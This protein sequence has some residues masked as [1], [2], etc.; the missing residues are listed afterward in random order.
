MAVE[1]AMLFS[2]PGIRGV[3]EL[4][5]TSDQLAL[6]VPPRES[7]PL[8]LNLP[9]FLTSPTVSPVHHLTDDACASGAESPSPLQEFWPTIVHFVQVSPAL[10]QQWPMAYC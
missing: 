2:V 6:V 4:L 3:D 1:S 9:H 8:T 7:V 10:L 5:L